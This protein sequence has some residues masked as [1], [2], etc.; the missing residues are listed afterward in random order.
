[1]WPLTDHLNGAKADPR[2]SVFSDFRGDFGSIGNCRRCSSHIRGR[3]SD[4]RRCVELSDDIAHQCSDLDRYYGYDDNACLAQQIC[5]IVDTLKA[6][7]RA[8]L[9]CVLPRIGY[10][11][12]MQ[13]FL[14]ADGQVYWVFQQHRR[15]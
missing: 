10:A 3:H 8:R 11:A 14:D 4:C 1:M 2:A 6:S 13:V 9:K 12:L 15:A 5:S 7:G